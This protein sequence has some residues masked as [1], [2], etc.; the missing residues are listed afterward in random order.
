MSSQTGPVM[1]RLAGPTH[2][3][4]CQFNAIPHAVFCDITLVRIRA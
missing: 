4:L 2:T 3:A 1:A